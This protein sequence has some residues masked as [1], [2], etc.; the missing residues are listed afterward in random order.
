ME[1]Y[2]ILIY[3]F[4]LKK[5]SLF[6][7]YKRGD[8]YDITIDTPNLEYLEIED[9]SLSRFVVKN[10]SQVHHVDIMYDPLAVEGLKPKQKKRFLELLNGIAATDLMILHFYTTVVLGSALSC[11]WP[12]FFNLTM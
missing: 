12:T 9:N 8:E 2:E 6:L 10:L 3:A 4:P 11:T 7:E 5:L 1:K